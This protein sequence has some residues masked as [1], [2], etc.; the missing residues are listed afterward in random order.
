MSIK[1][2]TSLKSEFSREKLGVRPVF[3]KC[4]HCGNIYADEDNQEE[5]EEYGAC[6]KCVELKT[7]NSLHL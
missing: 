6:M 7:Y 2:N 3:I 1:T 5:I 4:H